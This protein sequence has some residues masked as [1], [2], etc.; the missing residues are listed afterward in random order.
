VVR[1][2]SDAG[3]IVGLT[4]FAPLALL[5]LY[6]QDLVERAFGLAPLTVQLVGERREAA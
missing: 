6:L 5:P 2:P 4:Y 3:F 1:R